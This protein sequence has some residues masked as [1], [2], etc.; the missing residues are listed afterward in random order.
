[1][2][3]KITLQSEAAAPPLRAGEVRGLGLMLSRYEVAGGVKESI[4]AGPFRLRLRRL[5]TAESEL[6]INGRRWVQAPRKQ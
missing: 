4:E 3:Y 5:A 6:A 2:G 1:M